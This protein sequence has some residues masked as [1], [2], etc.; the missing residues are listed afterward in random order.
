MEEDFFDFCLLLKLHPARKQHPA[1][2]T[3]KPKYQQAVAFRRFCSK[4]YRAQCNEIWA[5]FQHFKVSESILDTAEICNRTKISLVQE[6]FRFIW[7][8]PG[9]YQVP[10]VSHHSLDLRR[11][12]FG[13]SLW[14]L[15]QKQEGSSAA[16][17]CPVLEICGD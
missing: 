10:T 14:K 1:F 3:P 2:P 7:N 12:P 15:H 6:S 17:I 13:P 8:H 5:L 9:I 11:T 4:S 16:G